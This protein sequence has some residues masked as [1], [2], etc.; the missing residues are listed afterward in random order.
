MRKTIV[1]SLLLAGTLL[2]L[3]G[4]Q[5]GDS[6]SYGEAVRIKITSAST[7][8]RTAYSGVIT[9]NK[10]R[11]DWVDGEKL[12][13]WSDIAVDRNDV[14]NKVANPSRYAVYQ[15]DGNPTADG[16]LS[17]A[18]L[19]NAP[20]ENGL[21]YV[22]GE[23]SYKFWGISPA[24]S[25]T[26]EDGKASFEIKAAQQMAGT[27]VPAAVNNVTTLP[28]DMSNAWLVAAVEGAQANKA[29][30]IPFYPAFTAFEFTFEGDPE[31]EGNI[32]VTKVELVSDTKLAGSVVATLVPGGASTYAC[33]PTAD[34]AFTFPANMYVSQTQKIVFTMFA[35]PQKIVGLKLRIYAKVDGEDVTF[36]GTM[37]HNGAPIEFDACKKY[38]I[39]G[40]AV[41]G[42]LWK[43]FYQPDITLD[44][45]VPVDNPITF[46]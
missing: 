20:G 24:T 2:S 43:I 9:N 18:S 7:S 29:V 27:T 23:D 3:A 6:V 13:I 8:T 37:K 26:P 45:W 1:I 10:E 46:E 22:D 35:L 32:N 12:L 31:Y 41:P 40:V 19:K 39:K 15:I 21:V 11:I 5:K 17:K 14:D 28:V 16:A 4:C 34:P 44:E 38:R 42:N 30:E 33:T 25:G 36:T